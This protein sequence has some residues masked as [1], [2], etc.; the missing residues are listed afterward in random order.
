[1]KHF[2]HKKTERNK[3]QNNVKMVRMIY[4]IFGYCISGCD[5]TTENVVTENVIHLQ[6]MYNGIRSVGTKQMG[7]GVA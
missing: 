4:Y 1:M 5:H 6:N 2:L 7:W 3:T